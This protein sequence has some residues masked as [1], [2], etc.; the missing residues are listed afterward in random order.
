MVQRAYR[1]TTNIILLGKTGLIS[2]LYV[3]FKCKALWPA[4]GRP[5][6]LEEP[7][8][9]RHANFVTVL[10]NL[11]LMSNYVVSG[12]VLSLQASRT[13]IKNSAVEIIVQPLKIWGIAPEATEWLE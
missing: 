6:L 2:N 7:V 1:V 10:K 11:H 9:G 4:E 12:V 13:E 5:K 3:N 8:K